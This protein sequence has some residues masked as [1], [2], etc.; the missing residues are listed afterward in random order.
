MGSIPA[1]VALWLFLGYLFVP[2]KY[3][4]PRLDFALLYFCGGMPVLL[5]I[6]GV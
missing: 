6:S 5:V 3:R 2:P 4:D 1:C